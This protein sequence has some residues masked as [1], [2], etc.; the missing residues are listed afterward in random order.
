VISP[1]D[2]QFGE[3]S[4]S[5]E[6]VHQVPYQQEGIVVLDHAIIQVPVV[7]AGLQHVCILLRYKKKGE[8]MGD[9]EGLM[10]PFCKLLSRNSLSFFCLVGVRG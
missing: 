3:P 8:A 9:F 2:I 10:Y 6:F 4:G 5:P 7:L 1:S